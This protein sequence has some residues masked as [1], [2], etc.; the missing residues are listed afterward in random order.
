MTRTFGQQSNKA[1][2]RCDE[3]QWGDVSTGR[4]QERVG[5]KDAENGHRKHRMI[6]GGIRLQRVQVR[7]RRAQEVG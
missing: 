7:K 4:T 2:R 1:Q 6:E 5:G 3:E